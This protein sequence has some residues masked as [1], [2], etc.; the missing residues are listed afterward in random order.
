[1]GIGPEGRP[2]LATGPRQ[3]SGRRLHVSILDPFAPAGEGVADGWASLP[4]PELLLESWFGLL[5][6]RPVALVTTRSAE[7]LSVFAEKR[8]RIFAL[9][10]SDRSRAGSDPLLAFE[11]GANLWQRLLPVIRDVVG[12]GLDDLVPGNWKG[13]KDDTLVLES[14]LQPG[15]G[16][17][18]KAPTRT[19]FD[20]DDAD[21]GRSPTVGIWTETACRNS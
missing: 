18:M 1:M 6:G 2:L 17:P 11:S 19:R 7:K 14:H 5:D 12:D 8:V 21:R 10:R 16:R 20:L 13:I 15:A 9:E 4:G 3:A